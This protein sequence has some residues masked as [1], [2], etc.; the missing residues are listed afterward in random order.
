M[1]VKPGVRAAAMKKIITI[2]IFLL[3]II[4][5]NASSAMFSFERLMQSHSAHITS[6]Q[7]LGHWDYKIEKGFYRVIYVEFLYGC[8]WLYI[9]WMQDYS[10][11]GY[12]KA[13]KTL[14]IY[15]ND[16][17]ENT[18]EQPKIIENKNGLLISYIAENG[19]EIENNKYKVEIQIFNE[20]GKYKIKEQKL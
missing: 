15:D 13:I 4:T 10:N 5:N 16:H 17:H 6:I 2:T 14:T 1:P 11:E 8:S 18:F 9:Q 7:S 19:H 20:P 3:F 12:T